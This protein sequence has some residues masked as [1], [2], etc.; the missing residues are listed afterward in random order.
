VTGMII[1]EVIATIGERMPFP[2]AIM[3]TTEPTELSFATGTIATEW[4]ATGT[5][6]VFVIVMID[7]VAGR[8]A[9]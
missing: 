7:S 1:V 4:I 2:P 8:M 9:C 3:T 6:A 5:I